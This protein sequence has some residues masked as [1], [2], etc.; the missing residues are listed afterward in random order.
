MTISARTAGIRFAFARGLHQ[1]LPAALSPG[2]VTPLD[3]VS[4]CPRQSVIVESR[5]GAEPRACCRLGMKV[6][7]VD[8]LA[9]RHRLVWQSYIQMPRRSCC[10]ARISSS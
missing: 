1:S 4:S 10:R 2:G 8:S 3:T 6:L 7:G 5:L 9:A